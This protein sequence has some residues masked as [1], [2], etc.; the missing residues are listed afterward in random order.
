M[1]KEDIEQMKVLHPDWT[2]SQIRYALDYTR[3]SYSDPSEYKPRPRKELTVKFMFELGIRVKEA[4]NE[5][6]WR[7]YQGDKERPIFVQKTGKYKS[8]DYC[9]YHPYVSLYYNGKTILKSLASILMTCVL[10]KDIPAGYVV[11]HIDN[12][13]FNNSLDN[14][15][16]L[17][18]RENIDKNPSKSVKDKRDRDESTKSVEEIKVKNYYPY[19]NG[20]LVEILN[21]NPYYPG[22]R[23]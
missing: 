22:E 9:K 10:L 4:D 19:D 1:R 14:L 16:L 2:D 23:K 15:Q 6:G 5:W 8:S 12:D 17:S 3:H 21:A 11:D 20:A 13:S 7:I 18:I